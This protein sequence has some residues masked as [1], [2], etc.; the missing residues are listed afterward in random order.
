MLA[1][2]KDLPQNMK[3]LF[4]GLAA[5]AVVALIG[6]IYQ[7]NT[8]G[9]AAEAWDQ[10][11][12]Q[13]SESIAGL[14]SDKTGLEGDKT[15]T[16]SLAEVNDLTFKALTASGTS[17]ANAQSVTRSVVASEAEGIHSHGLARLPTYCE[18]ARKEIRLGAAFGRSYLFAGSHHPA[19]WAARH[20]Q[21]KG[22]RAT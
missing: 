1:Q 16:L 18:H 9:T 7:S 2:L 21:R 3:A 6:N 14:E 10:E 11:R 4:G 15:V 17:E 22:G 5:V 8:H 12:I 13:L 20:K 19:T